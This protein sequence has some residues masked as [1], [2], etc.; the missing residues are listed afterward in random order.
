MI[1]KMT[2]YGQCVK[3]KS[4]ILSRSVARLKA[5]ILNIIALER[6]PIKNCNYSA[7]CTFLDLRIQVDGGGGET[8][9]FK[10]IIPGSEICSCC[11]L[12]QGSDTNILL[13][14]LA[15]NMCG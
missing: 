10:A 9:F 2:E 6:L 12:E 11:T 7:Y 3:K 5:N 8:V 1:F 13:G 4:S 14:F 15:R